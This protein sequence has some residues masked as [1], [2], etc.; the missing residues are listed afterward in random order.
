MGAN[1]W[2]VK[3][4]AAMTRDIELLAKSPGRGLRP[5]GKHFDAVEVQH[6][7]LERGEA[8]AQAGD[9]RLAPGERLD[10][11]FVR[12]DRDGHGRVEPTHEQLQSAAERREALARRA[13]AAIERET[14]IAARLSPLA[15]TQAIDASRGKLAWLHAAH[16]SPARRHRP[17]LPRQPRRRSAAAM[18]LTPPR[19]SVVG[20]SR[21]MAVRRSLAA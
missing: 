2:A 14:N 21:L 18:P 6:R 8:T 20:R 10:H 13:I 9:N 15:R 5:L 4:H 7:T 17:L 19:Q 3:S 11:R 1:E 16:R 12:I